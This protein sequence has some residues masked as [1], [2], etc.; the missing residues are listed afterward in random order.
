MIVRP[1]CEAPLFLLRP[2]AS[3]PSVIYIYINMYVYMCVCVCVY[4]YIYIHT[5]TTT[6]F[7]II[8]TTY[9]STVD[10]TSSCRLFETGSY[11]FVSS[12]ILSC[13]LLKLLSYHPVKL[14]YLCLGHRSASQAS[15][16]YTYV[17]IYIY[18]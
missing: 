16:I 8:P 17:Y 6:G 12:A 10:N 11:L 2:S 14:P 13:R 9:V 7:A 5:H 4:I 1:P 15:C 18:L 3:Q